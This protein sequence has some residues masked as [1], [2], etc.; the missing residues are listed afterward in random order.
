MFDIIIH[1]DKIVDPGAFANR[2]E[3]SALAKVVGAYDGIYTT[4]LRSEMGQIRLSGPG[5]IYS[6]T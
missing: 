4:H 5:A 1:K 6:T 2:K 3:L